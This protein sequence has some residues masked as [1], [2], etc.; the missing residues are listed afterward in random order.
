M[1]E[2]R[3]KEEKEYVLLTVDL[4]PSV[5]TRYK[6][7]TKQHRLYEKCMTS[8]SKLTSKAD[9]QTSQGSVSE[10]NKC[11]CVLGCGTGLQGK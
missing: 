9:R 4:H 11:V 1:S 3:R 7:L 2:G 5:N 6:I 8:R 10:L